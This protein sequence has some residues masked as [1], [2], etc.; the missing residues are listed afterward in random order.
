MNVQQG[1]SRSQPRDKSMRSSARLQSRPRHRQHD[2]MRGAERFA[3]PASPFDAN[4]YC[5]MHP[6]VMMAKKKRR[7]RGD[8]SI[9][10]D[11][12]PKCYNPSTRKHSGDTGSMTSEDSSVEALHR[13]RAPNRG[14]Q[15]RARPNSNTGRQSSFHS[16][17]SAKSQPSPRQQRVHDQNDRRR[18]RSDNHH[19]HNSLRSHPEQCHTEYDRDRD[20]HYRS[21]RRSND[22]R[23]EEH[24]N[25]RPQLRSR[26]PPRRSL[27]RSSRHSRSAHRGRGEQQR[28]HKTDSHG[29]VRRTVCVDGRPFDKHGRCYVHPHIKVA[30]KKMLG[31]WKIHME[32]CPLCLNGDDNRKS[33]DDNCSN[34]SGNSRLTDGTGFSD[35]TGRSKR[36]SRS[37]RSRGASVSSRKPNASVV[38]NGSARSVSSR[39][40][41]RSRKKQIQNKDD[42][43]LPLDG[44]GYCLYHSDVQLAKIE[45]KGWKVI[46]DFCPE[47][48]GQSVAVGDSVNRGKP[49]KRRPSITSAKSNSTGKSGKSGDSH[50]TYI[51]SMPYI[52]GDGKPGHY[53]G[54]VDSEGQPNGRGKMKYISG[55]KFD[56]VW[57][58]GTKLHGRLS[59][60]LGAKKLGSKN[61]PSM[62]PPPISNVPLPPPPPP[63]PLLPNKMHSR[64]SKVRRH[65]PD[66]PDQYNAGEEYK[67]IRR[68]SRRDLP[69][70]SHNE[71][72]GNSTVRRPRRSSLSR[73][74]RKCDEIE[75]LL[76]GHYSSAKETKD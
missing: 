29:Q 67:G 3:D 6:D 71:E 56:G 38:S 58:E 44:D 65:S 36:S 51:E 31:G 20:V 49:H 74:R 8:W 41:N 28:Q 19:H 25:E 40:S 1:R 17:T 72:E 73:L 37:C 53:T 63:P 42:S 52:D 27:S 60:K 34:I 24:T 18:N 50:S 5:M 32:F 15:Q 26:S 13:R 57:H 45:K 10:L 21:R 11:R 33:M 48:A 12:C 70:R 35:L 76:R 47:C 61:L 9:I 22:R 75:S 2:E 16:R 7:G 23:Q 69:A 66:S 46:L 14:H 39:T 62:H 54:H 68:N 59:K 4:G 43:F 55:I 30:S 64:R